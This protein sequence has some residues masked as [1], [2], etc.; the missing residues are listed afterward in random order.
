MHCVQWNPHPIIFTVARNTWF[1]TRETTFLKSTKHWIT[2]VLLFRIAFDVFF[3]V[4]GFSVTLECTWGAPFFSDPQQEWRSE[5]TVARIFFLRFWRYRPCTIFVLSSKFVLAYQNSILGL[6]LRSP[7]P[8]LTKISL[9]S[10]SN[11]Y[12]N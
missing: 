12:T 10:N 5:Y 9:A 3:I 2:T 4:V 1:I 6:C 11:L 7:F 8:S